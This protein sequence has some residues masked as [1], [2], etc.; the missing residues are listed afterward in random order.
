MNYGASAN[1][2]VKTEV[3]V[4]NG[5][6][7]AGRILFMLLTITLAVAVIADFSIGWMNSTIPFEWVMPVRTVI[8]VGSVLCV[9]I[10]FGSVISNNDER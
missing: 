1:V 5:L 6:R 3:M 10:C 8:Y 4:M 7:I 9:G 2:S